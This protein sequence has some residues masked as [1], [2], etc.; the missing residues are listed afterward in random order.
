MADAQQTTYHDEIR[1]WVEDRDGAPATVGDTADGDEPGVLTIHFD[2]SQDDDDR[3]VDI[4]WDD[5]FD[6]FDDEHLAFLHQ[7]ETTAGDVSRFFRV[8]NRS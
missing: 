3:L 6:K 1:R 5:W 8:V 2:G 4:G 7:D